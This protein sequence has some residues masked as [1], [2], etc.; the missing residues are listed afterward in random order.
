[1]PDIYQG[2]ELETLSLVDPD[3]RGAVDWERRKR[4]LG[5]GDT[6]LD[7]TRKALALRELGAYEPV[8]L[9]PDV[10]AFTRGDVL[11]AVPLRHADPKDPG[12]GWR[13]VAFGLY[14]RS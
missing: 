5:G 10:C 14:A 6:K 8:D 1:V 3:N 2:D 7:L 4:L 13:S 12:P 11:V 9:G